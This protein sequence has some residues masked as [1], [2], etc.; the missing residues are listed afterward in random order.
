MLSTQHLPMNEER[1]VFC[2][3]G[4]PVVHYDL[5]GLGGVERQVVG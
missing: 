3:P 2:L 4:L 5:L 1:R